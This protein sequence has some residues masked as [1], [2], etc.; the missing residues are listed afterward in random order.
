M[1]KDIDLTFTNHT[2]AA[3]INAKLT[4]F[5]AQIPP[6][7]AYLTLEFDVTLKEKGEIPIIIPSMAES[8]GIQVKDG[9]FKVDKSDI[10]L[11]N[12]AVGVV[13]RGSA[14]FELY[15]NGQ[16]AGLSSRM[17]I[18]GKTCIYGDSVALFKEKI[19][20]L[21]LLP[22]STTTFPVRFE[23]VIKIE[24]WRCKVVT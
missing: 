10:Y 1:S 5:L 9:T 16:P 20:S 4:E 12:L 6:P 23:G 24:Q 3:M 11:I 8:L 19:Y 17:K 14:A 7:T 15:I 22:D 13:G 2:L 21:T 18:I